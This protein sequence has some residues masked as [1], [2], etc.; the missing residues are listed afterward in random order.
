MIE[1]WGRGN[2]ALLEVL[3]GDPAMME[4]LGGPETPAKIASR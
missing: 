3:L 1:P 2:L 4:H